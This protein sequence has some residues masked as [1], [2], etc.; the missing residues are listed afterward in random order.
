MTGGAAWASGLQRSDVMTDERDPEPD[1]IV[2]QLPAAAHPPVRPEEPR[3]LDDM[4]VPP[5][6]EPN[7]T[8]GG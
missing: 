6:T 2:N 3:P 1:T 4:A 7:E 8:L 5:L